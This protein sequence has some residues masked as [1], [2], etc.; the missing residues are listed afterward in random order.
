M[1]KEVKVT[2]TADVFKKVTDEILNC[3]NLSEIY[4]IGKK[5][6][7]YELN[8]FK[9]AL[10]ALYR[11]KKREIVD[12]M[13]KE[14]TIFSNLYYII[15]TSSENTLKNVGKLL[16]NL[17]AT[18]VLKKEE[19]NELFDAYER[20]KEKLARAE[21]VKNASQDNEHED[22]VAEVADEIEMKGGDVEEIDELV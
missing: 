18:E 21:E 2:V 19:L 4:E 10:L 22:E 5:L 20:R 14:N 16:Y 8:G 3:S 13:L 15:M 9:R 17:K 11:E 1:E 7:E 12:N 6:A